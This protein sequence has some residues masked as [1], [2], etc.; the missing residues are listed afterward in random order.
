MSFSTTHP[1]VKQVF[2]TTDGK[3]FTHEQDAN[4]HQHTIDVAEKIAVLLDQE[5][6]LVFTDN[7]ERKIADMLTKQPL[8]RVIYDMLTPI[9]RPKS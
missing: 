4:K 2:Q 8:G 9:Y 5:D 3:T 1:Q 7:L 6:G